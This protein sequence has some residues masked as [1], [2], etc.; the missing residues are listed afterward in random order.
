MKY[1]SV[2]SYGAIKWIFL[3]LQ[4]LF[5]ILIFVKVDFFTAGVCL[6]IL[7]FYLGWIYISFYDV[8]IYKN[9]L[10]IKNSI[11][12]K[13]YIFEKHEFDFFER[14]NF[15]QSVHRICFKNGKKFYFHTYVMRYSPILPFGFTK[16]EDANIICWEKWINEMQD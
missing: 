3:T 10:I 1:I 9:R 5:L 4:F 15:S 16:K 14:Q 12:R 2:K 11:L 6:Y 8:L 7:S 13:E